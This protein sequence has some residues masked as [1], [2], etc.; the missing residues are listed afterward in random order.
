VTHAEL[1]MTAELVQDLLRDQ[2][3]D[4]ADLPV[5]LGARADHGR[6]GG[7]PTWGAPARA[8]LQRLTA[9]AAH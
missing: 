9:T 3:P 5:T 8:S 4:L 7:K 6:P 1:E 2:H